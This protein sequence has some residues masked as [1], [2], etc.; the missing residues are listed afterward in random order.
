MNLGNGG[1]LGAGFA[2][3]VSLSRSWALGVGAT[4]RGAFPYTAVVGDTAELKPGA[5][6]RVR[7]GA[8]GSLG[9]RTYLR[10][11]GVFLYRNNDAFGDQTLN[12]VGNRL[13]GYV[14]LDQ[15]VGNTTLNVYVYDVYRNKP[16]LESTAIGTA[17]LPRGN[18]FGAGARLDWPLG[19]A[20]VLTPRFEYRTALAADE[21]DVG[22]KR[23]GESFRFG[24]DLRRALNPQ[25]AIVLQLD[26]TT[27]FVRSEG[28]SPHFDGFRGAVHLEWTP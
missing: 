21:P 23:S 1:G 16:Q 10:V 2:G 18:L 9:R 5:D 14:S 12:G 4:L 15:G 24:A 20:T 27:G 22:L 28:V 25:F 6:V 11:A 7:L 8:E 19:S 3:A 17:V 13:V 26:G